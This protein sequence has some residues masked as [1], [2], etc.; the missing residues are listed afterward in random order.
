[1][2]RGEGQVSIWGNRRVKSTR[3]KNLSGDERWE[4]KRRKGSAVG[5]AGSVALARAVGKNTLLAF[6]PSDYTVP[7]RAA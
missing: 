4:R 5:G 3:S 1:M 7:N 2:R 6:E